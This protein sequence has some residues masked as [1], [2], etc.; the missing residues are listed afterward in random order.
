MP[1]KSI[2]AIDQGTTN[3]KALLIGAAGK[4][5]ARGSVPTGVRYPQPGWVEQDPWEIWR[6]TLDA[7]AQCRARAAYQPT[8]IAISNQRETALLWERATG[9]PLGPA[10]IWQCRRTTDFCEALKTKGAG[11][12]LQS[13]T[14]LQIDPMFSG[15]KL[16]WLLDATPNG[17][18]RAKAGEL[19]A[20]NVDAWLLWNLTGGTA[21]ATDLTNASRTQ[22]LNLQTLDWDDEILDL[23]GV[24]RALLPDLLPSASLFG[25]T[26]PT[27]LPGDDRLLGGIPIGAMIG[28]SHA[29]LYGLGGFRP[30]SI[31][32]TYGTG[33]SLMAPTPAPVYSSHGLS[34]TI[35][36]ARGCGPQVDAAGQASPYHPSLVTRH[37]S[38]VYALEGNIYTTGGAVQWIGELLRLSEPGPEVEALARSVPDAGGVTFVP[39]L[40]GLG[41]PYWAPAAQGLVTGLSLGT[42]PAHL[43]RATLDAVAFQVRDVFE[44]MQSDAGATRP[45]ELPTLLADGGASRNDLLM[46]LQADALG[47]PVERSHSSEVSALGAALLAGLTVSLWTTE[48][49]LT[50]LIPARDR[51]DPQIGTE[52]REAGYEAWRAAVARTL[53]EPPSWN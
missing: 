45:E 37:A 28:D 14:G 15:S 6:C 31:K 42:S 11:G 34:T 23:F 48:D 16:R 49:E 43:A 5:L 9:Q 52:K 53:F 47:C 30:G 33:T 44:A 1:Q 32:A 36:W 51:F 38:V 2:L 41:A 46:Q 17:Y 7:I 4:I 13:R 22:L 50:A 39:A 25:A 10:V 27:A 26:V 20:G 3:T 24:P 40:V 8:A 19:C 29:S 18:A 12:L 21:H 35:A